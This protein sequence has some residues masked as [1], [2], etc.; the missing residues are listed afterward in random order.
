MDSRD[1]SGICGTVERSVGG[2]EF[3]IP[4][5]IDIGPDDVG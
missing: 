1:R 3:T 2:N 5:R 4:E